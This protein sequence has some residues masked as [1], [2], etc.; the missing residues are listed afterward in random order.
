MTAPQ[1]A[2]P[3]PAWLASKIRRAAFFSCLGWFFP[4]AAAGALI[5][6]IALAMAFGAF[7]SKFPPLFWTALFLVGFYFLGR[8]FTAS[9]RVLFSPER[10]EQARYLR[11]LGSM[12]DIA[13][14]IYGELQNPANPKFGKEATLTQNWLVVSGGGRFAVRRLEDLVWGFVKATTT[15]LNWVVPI[16]RSH[17]AVFRCAVGPDAEAKCS[18]EQAE[19]LVRSVAERCPWILS[20]HSEEL[21]KL[22]DADR[23]AFVATIRESR[24]PKA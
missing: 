1:N 12:A 21:E 6:G 5:A 16:W 17:S 24:K 10:S 22:W 9:L 14:R 20:G 4:L 3:V 19:G 15:K 18:Q 7:E 2:E 23:A 13:N 8:E 11:G